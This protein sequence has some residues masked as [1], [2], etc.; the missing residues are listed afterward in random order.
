LQNVIDLNLDPAPELLIETT[1]HDLLW[2]YNDTLLDILHQLQF[3][4]D[5]SI[6]LQLNNSYSDREL[7]SIVH[8]GTKD[9][10]RRGQFIQWANLTELPF[11]LNEANFINKSTEGLF[12]HPIIHQSDK[13]EAFISDANR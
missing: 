3:T 12:F 1:V 6:S 5:R 4:P 11:W 2:G 10:Q 7:P 9:S 8:S 13:L